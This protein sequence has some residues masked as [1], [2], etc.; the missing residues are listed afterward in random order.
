MMYKHTTNTYAARYIVNVIEAIVTGEKNG[1]K[2]I[3]ECDIPQWSRKHIT[4]GDNYNY[5]EI[6]ENMNVNVSGEDFAGNDGV[7][8]A[9]LLSYRKHIG[10]LIRNSAQECGWELGVDSSYS[11]ATTSRHCSLML[12][13][14]HSAPQ[15]VKDMPRYTLATESAGRG[16]MSSICNRLTRFGRIDIKQAA[17]EHVAKYIDYVL[18][19]CRQNKYA[20]KRGVE[21]MTELFSLMT[22]CTHNVPQALHNTY[23][24]NAA[25][26]V[27]SALASMES[28]LAAPDLKAKRSVIAALTTLDK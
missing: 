17:N 22:L 13:K 18:Q 25:A 11:S 1:A 15:V 6:A 21:T 2:N 24:Y 28:I 4:A 23:Y 19:T 5:I 26:A 8:F 7:T 3:L 9:T 10:Y 12:H 20:D 14:I 27:N 16:V